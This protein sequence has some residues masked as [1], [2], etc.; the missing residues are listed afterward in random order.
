MFT[1]PDS[2]WGWLVVRA[3]RSG[4]RESTNRDLIG[5]RL[6]S[7]G[8][9]A[10]YG[11]ALAAAAALGLLVSDLYVVG[12][13]ALTLAPLASHARHVGIKRVLSEPTVITVIVWFYVGVFPL[14]GLAVAISHE[15]DLIFLRGPISSNDLVSMLLLA[16]ACTT[17]LIEAYYLACPGRLAQPSVATSPSDRH[18]AVVRLASLLTVLCLGGLSGVI[19]E[20]GG[21]AGARAS[22][23]QHT[24]TAALQGN[25]SLFDSAWQLFAVPAAWCC[26]YVV[27]NIGSS[28][29]TRQAFA[30]AGTLI[31][32]GAIGIYSSRLNTILGLMGMWVVYFYSG[33]RLPARLILLALPLAIL[34]SKPILDT[35]AGVTV[36]ARVTPLERYS[37]IAGYGVLD[38]ALA[39]RSRPE[40]IRSQLTS[41]DRWLA[42]PEYLVPAKLWPGRPNINSRRLVLYAAQD[43]GSVNDKATGLPATYIIEWWLIGGWAGALTASVLLGFVM[44]LAVRKLTRRRPSPAAVLV[45]AFLMTVGWGYY[46]TGDAVTTIV[47]QARAAAYLAFLL[48]ATGVIGDPWFR[49]K[50]VAP[51]SREHDSSH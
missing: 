16:A 4:Q 38:V 19:L 7:L 34:A 24:V 6:D 22:F 46:D 50:S 27:L 5:A 15:Q 37:R 44:G 25:S 20:H 13:G 41:L 21:I 17:L 32:A 48:W 28:R 29:L 3:V 11:L 40:E 47:G 1:G 42:L 51:L 26:A 23:V 18:Q 35:R 2:A 45:L 10:L 33:R 14:R 9:I 30:V 31:I 49:T 43:V 39:I 36:S 12:I 8:V